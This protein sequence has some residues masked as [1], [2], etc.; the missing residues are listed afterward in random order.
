[1][2]CWAKGFEVMKICDKWMKTD[3][4]VEFGLVYLNQKLIVQ[5]KLTK[6]IIG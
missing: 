3:I 4:T 6:I 5:L 1:M 2:T